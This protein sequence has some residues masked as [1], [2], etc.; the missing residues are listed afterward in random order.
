MT[1][2][3]FIDTNALRANRKDKG[4][5]PCIVVDGPDG[6]R[7]AHGLVISADG[8]EIARLVYDPDKPWSGT[9]EVWVEVAPGKSIEFS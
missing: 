3:I 9:A 7:E 6:R 4:C 5:R 8:V 2:R 1:S